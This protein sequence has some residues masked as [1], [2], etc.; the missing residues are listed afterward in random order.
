MKSL[1]Y[2]S[3]R[4]RANGNRITDNLLGRFVYNVINPFSTNSAHNVHEVIIQLELEAS[5][6]RLAL[7][8]K[9]AV[10]LIADCVR[11]GWAMIMNGK[12]MVKGTLPESCNKR[13]KFICLRAME[14]GAEVARKQLAC[15]SAN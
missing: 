7:R 9:W 14:V 6:Y 1:C 3:L 8:Q 12:V 15:Q 11:F 13:L 2:E 10:M 5:R 4:A